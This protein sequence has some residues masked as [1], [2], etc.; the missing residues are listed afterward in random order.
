[1][2]LTRRGEGV[3]VPVG[4][5]EGDLAAAAGSLRPAS[6]EGVLREGGF[7]GAREMRP[8]FAPVEALPREHAPLCAGG[9]K[10]DSEPREEVLA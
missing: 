1:M 4:D 3:E 6:G 5:R 9:I 7:G 10:V 2:E 8:P